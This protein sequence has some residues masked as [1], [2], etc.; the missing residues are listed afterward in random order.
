MLNQVLDFLKAKIARFKATTARKNQ[1]FQKYIS[2][3]DG[4][5]NAPAIA[6][7]KGLDAVIEFLKSRYK[8]FKPA[9][10]RFLISLYQYRKKLSRHMTLLSSNKKPYIIHFCVWGEKYTQ[11]TTE[12]LIP[13][14]LAAQNIPLIS[15][16][17]SITL[18]IH[19]DGVAKKMILNSPA[20]QALKEY[21]AI[22]FILIPR[23]LLT[24]FKKC[25][26][27]PEIFPF[28]KKL[29]LMNQGVK[30]TILG[31]LQTHALELAMKNKAFVSFFMPD[32]LFA[33]GTLKK[34]FEEIQGKVAV[35]STM[36]R[37][38]FEKTLEFMS[39]YKKS[40]AVLSIS[41]PELT[42]FKI[43]NM[44][45]YT[46]KQV[47]SEGTDNFFPCAQMIFKDK[48]GFIIR[49]LHY[50]PLLVDCETISPE[51]HVGYSTIDTCFFIDNHVVDSAEKY[52]DRVWVCT[53]SSE[54][55]VIEISDP[56]TT[57]ATDAQ[58]NQR[59]ITYKRSQLLD[60]V[61]Q[62]I[63]SSADAYDRPLYRYY[64]S[65]RLKV[66]NPSI[67][68]AEADIDDEVFLS[69]VYKRVNHQS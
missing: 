58:V 29:N 31:S 3:V 51:T 55:A 38:P 7:E 9:S 60:L 46:Q 36:Y 26:S 40:P 30:Y 32:F 62:M 20:G 10:I 34:A 59:P 2:G 44:H 56:I 39:A 66:T 64:V 41:S 24:A 28:F 21:L 42:K 13:S 37:T 65:H 25:Q 47:V 54:M 68:R 67:I 57:C 14:L 63:N 8:Y 33:N 27:Y 45:L 16:K 17:Y 18:L 11:R 35:V 19:C 1:A 52:E 61:V 53:D 12:L 4:L 22:D 5:S 48:R 50:H 6:E 43:E 49:A 23:R 15:K 69:E